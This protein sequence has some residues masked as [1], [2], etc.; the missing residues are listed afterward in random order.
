MKKLDVLNNE[1]S[2]VMLYDEERRQ[3]R[4]SLLA[5][6]EKTPILPNVQIGEEIKVKDP[7]RRNFFIALIAGVVISGAAVGMLAERAQ[8]GTFL[9]PI[10][11]GVNDRLRN[12]AHSFDDDAEAG[13][14]DDQ[15]EIE[16]PSSVTLTDTPSGE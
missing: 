10:K 16:D 14:Q 7:T 9:Y 8:P 13:I 6:I 11:V 5:Y 12:F 2:N 15:N 4:E 1:P 3:I